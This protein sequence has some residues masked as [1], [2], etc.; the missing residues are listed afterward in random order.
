MAQEIELK[1]LLPA[2]WHSSVAMLPW[3]KHRQSLR[4][5]LANTYFDT[6]EELLSS[7]RQT[8]RL[9]QIDQTYWQT[10]KGGGQRHGGLSQRN[11]LETQ[12]SGPA[13]E[14]EAINDAQFQHWQQAEHLAQR[15]QA[16]FQTNF[17]RQSWLIPYQNSQIE[18]ALDLG[19]IRCGQCAEPLCELELELKSGQAAD[20]S[21]LALALAQEL[22]VCP[23]HISKAGR[24]YRLYRHEPDILPSPASNDAHQLFEALLI[25]LAPWFADRWLDSDPELLSLWLRQLALLLPQ[26]QTTLVQLADELDGYQADAEWRHWRNNPKLGQTLLELSLQLPR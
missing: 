17:E 15:L 1:L 13:L 4:Q 12:V 20:L 3:L 9:R 5:Q 19:V 21:A 22:P 10:L 16:L 18:L 6:P 8:L 7:Q 11:E 24:G 23:G 26:Q 14:L 25:A 2:E